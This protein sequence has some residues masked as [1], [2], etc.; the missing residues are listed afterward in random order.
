MF[1][2]SGSLPDRRAHEVTASA[3]KINA[4]IGC[5]TVEYGQER[6]EVTG[7]YFPISETSQKEK[8]LCVNIVNKEK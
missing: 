1:R 5:L 2:A 8:K 4:G 3:K 6:N 7:E